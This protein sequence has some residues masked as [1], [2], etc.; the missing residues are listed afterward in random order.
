[1]TDGGIDRRTFLARAAGAG[2]AAALGAAGATSLAGCSGG[3]SGTGSTATSSAEAGTKSSGP[4]ARGGSLTVGTMAEIDGFYPSSNHWDTNGLLYANTVYDPLMAVAA[5]GSVKPYLAASLASNASHDVWTMALRPGVTFSD[6]SALTASVVKANFDAL[7]SSALAGQALQG[8][9]SVAAPDAMTVVFTLTGPAPSFPVALTTQ[10][11]YMVG[12][13]MINQASSH[14]ASA[15]TPVGTGPFVYSQWQ[16]GSFFTATRNPHYWRSGLPYLDQVTFKPIPDTTQR[17]STLRTGDVD[18]IISLDPTTEQR[19]GGSGYQVIDSSHVV[20]GEPTMG[21]VVLNTAVPPTKDL[22]IRQA[23]AKGMDQTQIQKLF[24]GKFVR[25]ADGLFVPG[26]PYHSATGYPAFD[27]SGASK[28]VAAYTAEH[29]A[30]SLQLLIT[31]DPRLTQLAEAMQQ[32][33]Q[34][35]GFHVSVAVVQQAELISDLLAGSFQA[36]PS[37]QFGAV[38]PNLNYVWLSSTTV[39][40]VGS[41]SLNFPRNSDPQIEAALSTARTTTD[42]AAKVSAWQTVDKRLAQDLPYLWIAQDIF[43]LVADSRVEGVESFTLPDGTAGYSF[44]EGVFWPVQV[45]L[46]R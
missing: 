39:S 33:W 2:G 8:L 28:L 31:T 38:D 3:S 16:Q 6:G 42:Q 40:P 43:T 1:M 45:G 9:S 25:P 30:P 15:P 4:P 20:I 11:G 29:G 24:W 27:P 12:E 17:E 22:R 21:F 36:V 46:A 23:L 37:A 18:L 34:Q 35:V 19:F 13:A 14:P 44:D 10:A 41:I 5:D 26:S 7:R 32:M